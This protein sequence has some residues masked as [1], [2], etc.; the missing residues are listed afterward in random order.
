MKPDQLLARIITNAETL[1]GL[2]SMIERREAEWTRGGHRKSSIGEGS[3]GSEFPIPVSQKVRDRRNDGT[4]TR[5]GQVGPADD[6]D[7]LIG[8]HK[9]AWERALVDAANALTRAA[10]SAAWFCEIADPIEDPPET[11]CANLRCTDMLEEGRHSGECAKC[12]KHRSRHNIEWP[13]L[14]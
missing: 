10:Q 9:K 5:W 7:R 11:P 6:V 2:I 3:R 12:R 4:P 8:R 1:Q 13:L 14:P